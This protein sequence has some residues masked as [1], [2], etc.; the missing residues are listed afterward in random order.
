MEISGTE[1]GK[2]WASLVGRHFDFLPEFGFRLCQVEEKWWAT[3]AVYR[4]DQLG[5]EVTRS[6]EFGRV[7][8]TLLRLVDGELPE[9]K[10]WVSEAPLNR[11]LF[12]NVLEAR[13][14]QVLRDLGRGLSDEDITQQLALYAELLRA[15]VPDFLQGSDAALVEGEIVIRERVKASPQ[16][17][18]VWLPSDASQA[19]EANARAEAERTSAPEVSISIRRYSG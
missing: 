14:P 11:V 2:R 19:E 12:D 9:V 17:L 10:V 18:T 3:T 4:S 15:V 16:E 8:L 6:V 13:N 5:L 1:N 7:E